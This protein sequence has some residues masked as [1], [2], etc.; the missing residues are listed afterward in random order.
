MLTKEGYP[1]NSFYGHKIIGIFQSL[2]EARNTEK[3]G[4][5]PGGNTVGAGDF[6]YEDTDGNGVVDA[7]D[8][9]IIGNPNIRNTFGSTLTADYKGF[10]FRV[11]FQGVLGRD[12]ENGVYGTD[13]MRS[14]ENVTTDFLDR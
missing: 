11:L 5:Q 9:V 14:L 2:E 3:Y 12:V 4:V 10:N 6:I 13:G 7:A 1:I 8:R